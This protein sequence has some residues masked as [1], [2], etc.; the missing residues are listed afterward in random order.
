MDQILK[1]LNVE[2]PVVIA[3]LASFIVLIFVLIKF[4]YR[5][6]E[7]ILQ[8]RADTIAGNLSAAEEERIKAND[9]RQQYEAQLAAVAEEARIKLEQAVKDAEHT[10]ERMIE[11][12]KAEIRE[13]QVRSQEQLMQDREKLRHELRSEMAEIAV[14]AAKRALRGNMTQQLSS[15]IIDSVITE[16]DKTD[17]IN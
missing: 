11:E 16:I 14:G 8:Q 4:L 1:S 2:M 13:I 3:Q 15:A 9:F 6:I 10:R 12:V 5:P 17:K 7:N